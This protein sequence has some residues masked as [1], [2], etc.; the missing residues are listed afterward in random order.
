MLASQ[1][2]LLS[3]E[4]SHVNHHQEKNSVLSVSSSVSMITYWGSRRVAATHLR[5]VPLLSYGCLAIYHQRRKQVSHYVSYQHF[6]IWLQG[7][8]AVAST[9]AVSFQAW[10]WSGFLSY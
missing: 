5:A 3:R 9:S 6:D 7:V 1:V 2:L 8:S 4:K 10:F